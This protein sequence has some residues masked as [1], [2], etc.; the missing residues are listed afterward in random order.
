MIRGGGSAEDLAAF[1]TEAVTRAVA[2]SRIPTLVAIGHEVDLSLAELAADRRASTPSNAAE[3][4]VPDR[5]HVLEQLQADV[6]SLQD[7]GARHLYSARNALDEQTAALDGQFTQFLNRLQLVMKG[8]AQLL[9]ALNP[10]AILRRGYAIVRRGK[11]IVR[12]PDALQVGAMID[13][14]LASGSFAA[15]VDRIKGTKGLSHE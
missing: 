4:L 5:R 3:L 6:I 10:A 8:H 2:A 12:S 14:Q 13:I 9:E 1:S 15:T 11:Q 7:Y